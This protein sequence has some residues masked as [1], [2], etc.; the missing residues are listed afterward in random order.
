MQYAMNCKGLIFDI[1]YPGE[2]MCSELVRMGL[3]LLHLENSL[4]KIW[5]G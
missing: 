1:Q 3:C 4:D 5:L 2:E